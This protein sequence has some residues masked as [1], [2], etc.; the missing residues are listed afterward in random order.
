MVRFS[1]RSAHTMQI[2]LTIATAAMN[3]EC[4]AVMTLPPS[5][6]RSD[7]QD[8]DQCCPPPLSRQE[9]TTRTHDEQSDQVQ[10]GE[11]RNTSNTA[12]QV[13]VKLSHQRGGR[14]IQVRGYLRRRGSCDRVTQWVCASTRHQTH[15]QTQ[16]NET[17]TAGSVLKKG[18]VAV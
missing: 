11:V 8:S 13:R 6:R 12:V 10:S 4:S 17:Y 1:I 18:T 5:P 15:R 3:A 7:R 16:L 9:R 14:P 2:A